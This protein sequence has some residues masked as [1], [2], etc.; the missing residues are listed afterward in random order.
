VIVAIFFLL[1]GGD[2]EKV[3][4]QAPVIQQ[5]E[6]D[7]AQPVEEE[8]PAVEELPYPGG[9]PAVHEAIGDDV[10]EGEEPE[11]YETISD[12][13]AGETVTRDT[14]MQEESAVQDEIIPD[15][16]AASTPGRITAPR[17][18]E[19]GIVYTVQQKDTLTEISEDTYENSDFWPLIFSKNYL[20]VRDP[21]L[22]RPKTEL[23]I[24]GRPDMSDTSDMETMY[25]GYI[26]AYKRYKGLG[27]D[28]KAIWL[29]FRGYVKVDK[30]ILD[31]PEVLEEDR[32]EVLDY[33]RRYDP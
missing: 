10:I 21:D 27:K 31:L 18:R 16:T 22:I 24:P 17:V 32:I 6:A 15:E 11:R 8:Q 2:E 19:V 33:I 28:Q 9:K 3:P 29:L 20:V 1:S 4:V 30:G 25:G 5:D 12:E 23:A 14:T 26:Q 13:T 7:L